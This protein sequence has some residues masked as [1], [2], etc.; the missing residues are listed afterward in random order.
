[1]TTRPDQPAPD[2]AGIEELLQQV[3]ARDE[4]SPEMER[5]VYAAVHAEWRSLVDERQKKR[6]FMV[7]GMAASFVLVVLVA[8]FSL[9]LMVGPPELVASVARVD[10]GLMVAPEKGANRSRKVGEPIV[11]GERVSTD[12]TSRAA[13]SIGPHLS[14]RL[15]HDTVVRL[16]S[17]DRVTL[18]AGTIYVD[19]PPSPRRSALTVES[20]AGSVRHYGTQ[21][22][23]RDAES[24]IEI[25]VREGRI[26]V[27]NSAG[28]SAGVAG[29]RLRV[30]NAGAVTRSKIAPNDDF[31][32]WVQDAAPAFDI[33]DRT[34]AAFLLWIGRETGREI[35][36]ET[37]LAE[38]AASEAKLHGS[39][40]G[41]D[42]DTALATV[43]STTQLRQY[44]AGG[45]RIGIRLA[46]ASSPRD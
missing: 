10:G 1:M 17:N 32:T 30:T 2:D 24:G 18:E 28:T 45:G 21:Y 4:P 5:E 35:V 38:T 7:W 13:L 9:E 37:S 31:W 22:S 15:D 40:D 26:I 19:D 14:L 16:A 36:Y 12:A 43:L 46:A 44:S 3:G 20:R 8:T 27:T 42:L 41:L 29:E 39:I 33:N 25:S 34:L 6:R 23:V 11:A